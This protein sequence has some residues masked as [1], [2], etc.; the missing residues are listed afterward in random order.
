MFERLVS[1]LNDD[2]AFRLIEKDF[3]GKAKLDEYFR[4]PTLSIFVKKESLTNNEN[5]TEQSLEDKL[6]AMGDT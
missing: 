4:S 5:I 1:L 3:N 2:N 6:L